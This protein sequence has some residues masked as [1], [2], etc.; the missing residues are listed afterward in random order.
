M[1]GL[2][3]ALLAGLL[4]AATAAAVADEMP[5]S[6]ADFFQGLETLSADFSQQ[7]VDGNNREIQ[8]ATGRMWIRRPGMFRWDYME[9]YQQQLVADGE[10]LWSY[11][12]DLEQV[13]VQ[14]ASEVLTATPAM[15]LSGERP[16]EDV[17]EIHEVATQ[18]ILLTPKN[19]DSNVTE[20]RLQFNDGGLQRIAAAD[21][22]GNT[23]VFTFT[24]VQRNPLLDRQLFTFEPPA[25]ADVVGEAP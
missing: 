10:R 11:D 4:W 25:G 14:A 6:L 15:L 22:F 3:H 2:R 9:P 23:T 5:A 13:T 17:F 1:T 12:K 20:L 18:H 19:N 21:T 24:N 7:V 16:L 8:S